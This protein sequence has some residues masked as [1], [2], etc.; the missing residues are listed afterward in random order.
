M[1]PLGQ[2]SCQRT[3]LIRFGQH[4]NEKIRINPPPHGR[5]PLAA[6]GANVVAIM[7]S[8]SNEN[9][10]QCRRRRRCAS[11]MTT[12]T[13]PISTLL[14]LLFS[15]G[16]RSE[17]NHVAMIMMVNAF[18]PVTPPAVTSGSH[19]LWWPERCCTV[20][21]TSSLCGSNMES[22]NNDRSTTLCWWR[23]KK[24]GTHHR[25]CDGD[26]GK[27][28]AMELCMHDNGGWNDAWSGGMSNAAA[29]DHNNNNNDEVQRVESDNRDY[30]M[31][32]LGTFGST[33]ANSLSS[34]SSSS[35]FASTTLTTSTQPPL[36]KGF[37][38]DD[39]FDIDETL[40]GIHHNDLSGPSRLGYGVTYGR[41]NTG[42]SNNIV[43]SSS[44]SMEIMY[45]DDY[46][47]DADEGGMFTIED[48]EIDGSIVADGTF[49]SSSGLS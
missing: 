9:S 40:D 45:D 23:W 10:N 36:P 31:T 3:D 48:P 5:W 28:K 8:T 39:E 38:Y 30:N 35:S 33:H 12:V 15:N 41:G 47:L 17:D 7:G 16:R 18:S 14:L 1:F 37:T 11:S 29:T 20:T 42:N 44:S 27:V 43:D 34:S 4:E 2:S 49:S 19:Q 13:V 21:T 22:D 6:R 24:G 46:F 26:G 32:S 25:I